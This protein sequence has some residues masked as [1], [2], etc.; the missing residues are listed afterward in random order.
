MIDPRA[1]WGTDSDRNP[2]L[3]S[4]MIAEIESAFRLRLPARRQQS[5][6]PLAGQMHHRIIVGDL[7]QCRRDELQLVQIVAL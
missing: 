3:T 4:A 2:P 5:P 1:F 7:P 6:G